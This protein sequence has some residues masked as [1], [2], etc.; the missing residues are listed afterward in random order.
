MAVW[1]EFRGYIICAKGNQLL[2][3]IKRS[4]IYK[5]PGAMKKLYTTLVR[6]HLEHANAVWSPRFKKDIER[7]EQVQRRATKLV[8]GLGDLPY[9][10]RLHILQLPSLVYRQ[11]RGDMIET[12]KYINNMYYFV[13]HDYFLPKATSSNL[14][15]HKDAP[16]IGNISSQ[17]ML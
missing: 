4:F 7:I 12:Y 9:T 15:A 13:T 14:R 11:Y 6:P 2:G 5:E 10:R 1:T 16:K 3:L 8:T 17:I